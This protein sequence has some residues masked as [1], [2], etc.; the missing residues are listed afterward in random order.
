MISKL[1][2]LAQ[3]IWR[4][5]WVRVVLISVFSLLALAIAPLLTPF[6]PENIRL[7]LGREAVLPVLTILA[8]GMLAV[9]TFSLN[10][11]VSA[12]R[13]AAASATTVNRCSQRAIPSETRTPNRAGIERSPCARSNSRSWQA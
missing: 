2:Y 13:A 4:T 11:M 10:V 3:H 5:L 12:H 7:Q 8:S 1:L 9:T 6:I